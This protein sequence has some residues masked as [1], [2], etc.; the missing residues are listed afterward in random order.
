MR[1]KV[2]SWKKFYESGLEIT[3][4]EE[5]CLA[6]LEVLDTAIS[7]AVSSHNYDLAKSLIT[8]RINVH[9]R[10][11]EYTQIREVPNAERESSEND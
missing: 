6:I 5:M 11:Y 2:E 3:C 8:D 10:L 1:A 9:D 7:V 4:D